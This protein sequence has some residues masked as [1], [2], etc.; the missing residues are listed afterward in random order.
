VS[1]TIPANAATGVYID[2]AINA[3]FSEAMHPSTITTVTFTLAQ[4]VTPVTGTVTYAGVTATFT[5]TVNL[6]PST[7][8]TVTIT[9]GAKDLDGNALTVNKVWTFITG[10]ST[11]SP[12]VGGEA[13][14]INKA[15]VLV[16]WLILALIIVIG[17]SVL[18]LRRRTSH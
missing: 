15:N 16:P 18:V 17:G 1:S 11:S 10:T 5:P 12:A 2:T 9:T 7:I 8:Y 14:P 6:A 3:V 13:Y 4:G